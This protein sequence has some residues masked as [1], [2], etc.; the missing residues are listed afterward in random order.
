MLD[1]NRAAQR[2]D[3]A[4]SDNV[5]LPVM[6]NCTTNK[7]SPRRTPIV[8]FG[9]GGSGTRAVARFL[10]ECHVS[11]G[12]RING[13]NDALRF[14]EI[15]NAHAKSILNSTHCL[16]YD[17]K[18]V[19]PDVCSAVLSGYRRAGRHHRRGTVER[20]GFKEPRN[21]FLLP[22]IDLAFP[23]GLFVHV[24]RDGRDML[25]S[26]NRNQ[27]RKYYEALFGCSFA[28]N[29]TEIARFWAKTNMEARSFAS[30]HFKNRYVIARIEDLCGPEKEEHVTIFSDALALERKVA[31]RAAN[32]FESQESFG[33]GR[34][35][36]LGYSFTD[37]FH[38]A[39][40]TFQYE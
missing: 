25:L 22:L 36:S 4:K 14:T 21:M 31:G 35:Q 34:L 13:S 2:V 39:L 7:R 5:G 37:D 19:D 11:M 38:N 9:T 3:A 27:P 28:G 23:G 33:R 20:W 16:N 29:E 18:Q 17:P 1:A 26:K 40:A 15:I 24:V 12:D 30:A 8:V 10:V 6:L 32:I